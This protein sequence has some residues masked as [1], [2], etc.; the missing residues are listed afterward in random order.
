MWCRLCLILASLT[1]LQLV[2]LANSVNLVINILRYEMTFAQGHQ[3]WYKMY[4]L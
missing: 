2:N 3:Q 1:S 4:E